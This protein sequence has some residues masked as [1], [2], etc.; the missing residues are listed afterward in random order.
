[1]YSAVA[2]EVS[3]LAEILTPARWSYTL[4]AIKRLIKLKNYIDQSLTETNLPLKSA[5]FWGKLA[6][7]VTVLTPFSVATNVIQQDCATLFDVG[8]QFSKLHEHAGEFSG[9]QD[10]IE[11]TKKRV[12]MDSADESVSMEFISPIS[13]WQLFATGPVV[14]NLLVIE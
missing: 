10:R 14:A 2:L 13:V 6:D 7:L 11:A 4:L 5:T 9:F 8:V 3:V 1:M 12:V